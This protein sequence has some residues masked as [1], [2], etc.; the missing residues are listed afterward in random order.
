MIG[1]IY[2][3]V[4]KQKK[5]AYNKAVKGKKAKTN[6]KI[7]SSDS[8]EGTEVEV[9]I[10]QKKDNKFDIGLNLKFNVRNQEVR[11]YTR[12]QDGNWLYSMKTVKLVNG[13]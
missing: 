4:E 6:E 2:V 3:S 11:G 7:S 10:E 1:S 5:I 13:M 9:E 12:K 8:D